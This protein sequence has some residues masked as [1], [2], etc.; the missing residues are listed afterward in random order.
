MMLK[1]GNYVG[2]LGSVGFLCSGLAGLI[3]LFYPDTFPRHST[4]EGVMLIGAFL[5]TACQRLADTLIFKPFLYY[6]SL[7][8]LMLL[9]RYIGEKTQSEII[10]QLTRIYFLGYYQQDYVPSKPKTT[11]K[12]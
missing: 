1:I 12:H 9:R 6:V 11:A 10:Q 4:L 7:V 8:Q 3:F 5:G 2:S